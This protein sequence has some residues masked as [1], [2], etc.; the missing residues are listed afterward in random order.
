MLEWS[1]IFLFNTILSPSDHS[2]QP[3]FYKSGYTFRSD[4]KKWWKEKWMIHMNDDEKKDANSYDFVRNGI[5]VEVDVK[6]KDEVHIDLCLDDQHPLRDV[7]SFQAHFLGSRIEK[8]M[9]SFLFRFYFFSSLFSGN[10]PFLFVIHSSLLSMMESM[11]TRDKYNDRKELREWNCVCL[12]VLDVLSR[13]NVFTLF[14]WW[15]FLIVFSMESRLKMA[16]L[17]F[18]RMT[19]PRD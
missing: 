10:I 13:L 1:D 17:R 14:L 19:V 18:E 2:L 12:S 11:K 6:E 4:G 9:S 3:I 15:S 16:R 8:R 5:Y 7:S